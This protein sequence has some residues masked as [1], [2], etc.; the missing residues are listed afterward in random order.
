MY[1]ALIGV[2][3][4]FFITQRAAMRFYGMTFFIVIIGLWIERYFA[5]ENYKFRDWLERMKVTRFNNPIIYSILAIQLCCGVYAWVFDY[6]Y[7]FT[8]AKETVEFLKA[9]HLDSREIVTV[10][11]DG[12][13]ISAY[14]GRKIWF[15]CEGGYHSFCQ[16]DLGCAGK[17]TPGNISGLLSDYMETHSDAIFVSY[18]PLSLGFPKS[19]EWAELN[20]KVQ[21]RFLKSK[22][23]VYIADNGYLYVFEVRKKPSP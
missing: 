14:L 1:T 19:N 18:Y 15:L 3:I 23:D 2:Q 21:F 16:W 7:P 12:T 13:I 6:R 22:S 9:K 11:C 5:S 4:F 20:E 10:T 17:I 8:S